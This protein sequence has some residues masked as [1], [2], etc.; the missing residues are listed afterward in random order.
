MPTEP[1]EESG[2]VAIVDYGLGNLFSVERACL[3]VGLAPF[4]TGSP[5]N[6]ESAD[7]I[8]LPGVGAFGA[9][10]ESLRKLDLVSVIQDFASSNKPIIGI[11]LGIQLLMTESHEFGNHRGLNI[12]PG[13]TVRLE[14]RSSEGFRY[15]V[16]HVGWNGIHLPASAENGALS[17]ESPARW[18]GSPLHGLHK[19]DF[20]YFVHSFYP[21]PEDAE[22]VLSTTWHGE[23]EF[24]SSLRRGNIFACQFHPERSGSQGIQVYR[25]VANILAKRDDG[26]ERN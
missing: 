9:A 19:G 8:V 12:I 22:V 5:E 25:N 15:K 10:M 6:V 3:E 20:M 13:E 23:I 17:G 14:E 21:V 24:C 16:P 2:R 7:A 18:R 1:N 26:L 11:C 4:I